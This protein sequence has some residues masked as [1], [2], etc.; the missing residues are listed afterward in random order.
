MYEEYPDKENYRIINSLGETYEVDETEMPAEIRSMNNPAR[1]DLADEGTFNT[2]AYYNAIA[3]LIYPIKFNAL[4]DLSASATY[5]PP[6]PAEDGLPAQPERTNIYERGKAVYDLVYSS[7]EINSIPSSYTLSEAM[8]EKFGSVNEAVAALFRAIRNFM[9]GGAEQAPPVNEFRKLAQ[10]ITVRDIDSLRGKKEIYEWWENKYQLFNATEQ[11]D[12][13]VKLSP[14]EAA[15]FRSVFSK[16]KM[17]CPIIAHT[18]AELEQPSGKFGL[19]QMANEILMGRLGMAPSEEYS[20]VFGI[21]TKVESQ[22]EFDEEGNL[23]APSGVFSTDVSEFSEDIEKIKNSMDPL[24]YLNL[25]R[26]KILFLPGEGETREELLSK[27]KSYLPKELSDLNE[28]AMNFL[29][30]MVEEAIDEYTSLVDK[31]DRYYLPMLDNHTAEMSSVPIVRGFTVAYFEIGLEELVKHEGRD[32]GDLADTHTIKLTLK[33]ETIPATYSQLMD[34]LNERIIEL[35]TAINSIMIKG[36]KTKFISNTAA[37]ESGFATS[38]KTRQ[39]LG[40]GQTAAMGARYPSMPGSLATIEG[41]QYDDFLQ[42][43][44]SRY[45]V[46]MDARYLFNRDYPSY[47]SN[48]MVISFKSAYDSSK[49]KKGSV[50]SQQVANFPSTAIGEEQL[51]YLDTFIST[52]RR[53]ATSNIS[54]L[55]TSGE[56]AIEIYLMFNLLPGQSRAEKSK[57]NKS[58]TNSIGRIIHDYAAMRGEERLEKYI[59]SGKQIAE[60]SN[61]EID[62]DTMNI[63]AELQNPDFLQ[64]LNS[65]EKNIVRHISNKLT[66]NFLVDILGGEDPDVEKSLMKAIDLVRMGNGLMV[67]KAH[68]DMAN[69]EDVSAVSDLIKK[70]N[71]VDLYAQDMETIL[72]SQNKTF[73]ELSTQ[74]GVSEEVIYKVRGLF[75]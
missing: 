38:G 16:V 22:D 39:S 56:N 62:S 43:V 34:Y 25:L 4:T 73:K 7:H 58:I 1:A 17:P 36:K 55:I 70:E 3:R 67:Y 75:R 9:D 27:I 57:L 53:G 23:L 63:L 74:L 29:A 35:F 24:T 72:N 66:S 15:T 48:G 41:N 61:E 32:Y 50:I 68:F 2:V 13:D 30:E 28:N 20:K 6:K 14:N 49:K 40:S 59:F 71:R 64:T 54:N 51:K 33:N 69:V 26:K 21:Q 8:E 12:L 11:L 42:F 60:Y 10:E 46:D 5:T 37:K 65:D 31:R 52:L 19:L 18:D 44:Y 47:F 45:I